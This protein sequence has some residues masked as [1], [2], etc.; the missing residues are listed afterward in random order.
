MKFLN[1]RN[2]GLCTWVLTVHGIFGRHSRHFSRIIL[3]LGRA[4]LSS[5]F[6]HPTT[7]PDCST[8]TSRTLP[9]NCRKSTRWRTGAGACF[10]FLFHVNKPSGH[11]RLQ[12]LRNSPSAQ[13]SGA[14]AAAV[15]EAE[16][17]SAPKSS[18]SACNW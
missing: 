11:Q 4:T 8:L 1:R 16:V 2:R 3:H 13:S 14:S 7:Q 9:P 15:R 10:E 17:C 5:V 6:S 12:K 18:W